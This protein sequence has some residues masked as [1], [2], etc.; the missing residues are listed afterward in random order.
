MTKKSTWNQPAP[1]AEHPGPDPEPAENQSA[2][3]VAAEIREHLAA[4]GWCLLQCSA[5]GGDTIV[6]TIDELVTGYPPGHPVYLVQELA[7]LAKLD[8]KMLLLAH[9]AKRISGARIEEAAAA[10]A[11]Q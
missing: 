11:K 4:K 10:G 3:E 8:D 2:E 9:T 7:E 6:V 1:I 5:L